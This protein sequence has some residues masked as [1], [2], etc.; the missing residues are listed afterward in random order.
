MST[1]V[2][3]AQT[4]EDQ[5]AFYGFMA[6]L[7]ADPDVIEGVARQIEDQGVLAD[8]VTY[9]ANII[10]EQSE[11]IDHLSRRLTELERDVIKDRMSRPRS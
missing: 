6:Q 2:E 10:T 7:I 4:P 1:D 8:Q 3:V 11:V 9:L 5:A